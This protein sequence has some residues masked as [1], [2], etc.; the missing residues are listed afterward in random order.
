MNKPEVTKRGALD[1]Q[2]C[3]PSTWTNEQVKTFADRENLCGTQFGWT[4]RKKGD[5]LLRDDPERQPC[6][7]RDGFVHIM[8]DA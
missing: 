5:P 6:K 8:L 3:V 2:V 7:Q 4:I 1:M